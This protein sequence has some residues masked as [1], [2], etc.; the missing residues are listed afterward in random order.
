M[1]PGTEVTY[2]DGGVALPATVT[3][4]VGV[5]ASTFKVVDL[6]VGDVMVLQVYHQNDARDT[7]F[8]TMDPVD[9]QPAQPKRS[10]GRKASGRGTAS[11]SLSVLKQDEDEAE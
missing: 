2:V 3:G 11:A 4:V 5:G 9:P 10:S 8:W 1:R 7:K 6:I